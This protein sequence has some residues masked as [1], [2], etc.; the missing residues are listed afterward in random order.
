MR[1]QIVEDATD[2]V[3]KHD[4][5]EIRWSPKHYALFP[6]FQGLLTVRPHQAGSYLR[7]EG[8]YEPPFGIL[9]RLF[10]ALI[11]RA[12]ARLTL[13]R[14]LRDLRVDIEARNAAFIAERRAEMTKLERQD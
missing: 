6:D 13:A 12:L 9:G 10:D 1:S 7:I 4:A 5:L 14:L 11:G 8:A 2:E 3:R